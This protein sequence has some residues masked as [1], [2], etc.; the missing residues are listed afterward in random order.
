MHLFAGAATANGWD[1]A[2]LLPTT[3]LTCATDTGKANKTRKNSP[4]GPSLV[5]SQSLSLS[6]EPS[7]LL[8]TRFSDMF[9]WKEMFATCK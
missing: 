2:P 4:Q 8:H 1:P 6:L 7:K 5:R 9:Q 3:Q